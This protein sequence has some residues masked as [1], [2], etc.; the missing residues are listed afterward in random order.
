MKK[1]TSRGRDA[2]ASRLSAYSASAA[3]VALA[4]PAAHAT[5]QNITSF[6]YDGGA[7]FT[8]TPPSLNAGTQSRYVAG[9]WV[10]ARFSAGPF[11]GG[12]LLGRPIG[13]FG[14]SAKS[15]DGAPAQMV[16]NV[17]LTRPLLDFVVRFKS[18]DPIAAGPT[19]A[20]G[21]G[22][23][24]DRFSLA[25]SG[26]FAPKYTHFF[27]H[28]PVTGY[29]GF[30]A[31]RNGQDYYGWLRVQATFNGYGMRGLSLVAK[32]GEPGIYGAYGLAGDHITAGEFSAVPEPATTAAG[33]A[34]F[35]L[36][37]VGVREL[38]RRRREAAV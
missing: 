31:E 14:T 22:L 24:A 36:G 13:D 25:N 30:K 17:A 27:H 29:A 38:R 1:K 11:V 8:T 7:T 20:F 18:G 37:A 2:F 6:S 35:A 34:L 32:A 21:D 9:T 10:S 23:L 26:Q 3:V 33:L 19:I 4:A 5:I 12:L 15:G 28:Y 16:G